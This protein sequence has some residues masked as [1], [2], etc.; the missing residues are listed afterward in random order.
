[1]ID[2]HV[3]LDGSLEAEEIIDVANIS[4]VKLP[5][6]DAKN[7]RDLL[8]VKESCTSLGEYLEK[9]ELPLKVLQTDEAIEQAVFL[10]VEKLAKQGLCYAE[11]RFAPQLHTKMGFSQRQIVSAAVSGL[12]KGINLSGMSA[13]LI[14][15]CMRGVENHSEN[16]Q[17]VDLAAEF[18]N[19]GVCALDLAGNEADYPTEC[20]ADLF[21][22][23]RK[24]GIPITIHAGEAAGPESVK[25]ALK[26]GAVRIGHGI[27]SVENQDLLKE[28]KEKKIILETC[29][30]S[31]LQT[32]AV[33]NPDSYPI[34]ELIDFGIMVTINTDN[35]SV[36]DTT[37]KKEYKLIQKHFSFDKDTLKK[38]ALNAL[39]GA[40]ISEQAKRLLF[41]HIKNNF[42]VWLSRM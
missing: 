36:S 13:Q 29:F 16:M 25:S 30:S 22:N 7:L 35:M 41:E 32:K 17:T 1:M 2:L 18:L 38:L 26:L 11:I 27:H 34:A 8:T 4:N 5:E 3:H 39:S 24:L 12:Y 21:K 42:D 6:Y 33:A 20:F 31:N 37:L 14:L 40:F 19:K 23:A 9:F 10:L 15:C 28:L